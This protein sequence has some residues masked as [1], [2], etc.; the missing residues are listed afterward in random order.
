MK[1]QTFAEPAPLMVST[2]S[3]LLAVVGHSGFFGID[4]MYGPLLDLA[5]LLALVNCG[6]TMAVR[7]PRMITTIRISISVTPLRS[8][9]FI[10]VPLRGRAWARPRPS[11]PAA[12]SFPFRG[13]DHQHRGALRY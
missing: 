8:C 3:L 12:I 9:P 6:I 5:S 13:A 10:K 11:R 1:P 7:M 4:C 2:T